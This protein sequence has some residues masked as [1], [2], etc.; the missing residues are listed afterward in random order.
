MKNESKSFLLSKQAFS[1]VMEYKFGPALEKINQAIELDT[2]NAYA[3][4]T[5]AFILG[6]NKKYDQSLE[7]C[8]KALKINSFTAEAWMIAGNDLEMLAIDEEINGSLDMAKEYHK[9]A[10]GFWK[11]AKSISPDIVLPFLTRT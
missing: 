2:N 8:K 7:L 11:E 6:A 10:R 5:K 1:L 4:C 3:Y 9:L